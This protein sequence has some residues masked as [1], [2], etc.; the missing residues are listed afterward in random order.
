MG[1][2]RRPATGL[3]ERLARQEQMIVAIAVALIVGLAAI[4][5]ISGAGMRMSALQMTRMTGPLGVSGL[6]GAG[7]VWTPGYVVLIFLMWWIMMIAMMTPSAAP[8]L[9]LYTALKRVGPDADRARVLG[10]LFL[11]GYLLAWAGFS[12]LAMT[13]QWGVEAAGL[14]SGRTM[15]LS[16]RVLAAAVLIL[17][18]AWQFSGFKDACLTHCRSPGEFLSARIRP[19]ATGALRLGAAHGLYCLGCCWA[20]MALLFV[21]GIMNLYWIVGL[22]LF[23]LGEKTLPNRRLL[24]RVV[25]AA[26]VLG[27]VGMLVAVAAE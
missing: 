7:S 4:Y 14:S 12:L 1:A 8:T 26:L 5:T 13:A 22:A 24:S 19:G 10:G 17:A 3:V 20:L 25:G 21:G 23:V 27:G 18:G 16:S 9:L 11:A 6:A 15:A 2:N